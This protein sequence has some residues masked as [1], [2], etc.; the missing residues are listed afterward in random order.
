M[1]PLSGTHINSTTVIML[2]ECSVELQGSSNVGIQN[3]MF[4][5][6]LMSWDGH[7]FP[8]GDRRLD[9]FCFTKLLTVWHKCSLKAYLLKRLRALEEN[10]IRNLDR[11]VIQLASMDSR[12]P[13]TNSAWNGLVFAE[14]PSLAVF[15]S[16]CCTN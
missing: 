3:A 10:T 16:T 13:K 1:A 9:L 5:I 15:G 11:L 14:A 7:F 12:F 8:N 6:C 4:L 2:I